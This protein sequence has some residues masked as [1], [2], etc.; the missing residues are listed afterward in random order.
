[1]DR[2][3]DDDCLSGSGDKIGADESSNPIPRPLAGQQTDGEQNKG[4]LQNVYLFGAVVAAGWCRVLD[5]YNLAGKR[6]ERADRERVSVNS[7]RQRE[8]WR[9]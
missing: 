7:D 5:V 4:S 1:M 9:D 6:G 8:R 3:G 2:I